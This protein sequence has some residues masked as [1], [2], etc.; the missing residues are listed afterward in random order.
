MYI[1]ERTFTLA[2]DGGWGATFGIIFVMAGRKDIAIVSSSLST[3]VQENMRR[4]KIITTHSPEKQNIRENRAQSS[5][6]ICYIIGI[7]YFY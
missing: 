6:N 7:K 5:H 1:Y 2:L 4:V 3:L